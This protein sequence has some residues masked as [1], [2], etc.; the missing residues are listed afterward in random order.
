MRTP[1]PQASAPGDIAALCAG[2]ASRA[3]ISWNAQRPPAGRQSLE[4]PSRSPPDTT[5][6]WVAAQRGVESA[7]LTAIFHSGAR[8]GQDRVKTKTA[9]RHTG[10]ERSARPEYLVARLAL[11]EAWTVEDLTDALGRE[12]GTTI[13]WVPVPPGFPHELCG[14]HLSGRDVTVLCY[15]ES[16]EP[17]ASRQAH[18][19][20][21][22]HHLLDNGLEVHGVPQVLDAL[23][24][25]SSADEAK[26]D[27]ARAE[28]EADHLAAMILLSP[29]RRS[30]RRVSPCSARS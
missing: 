30:R 5:S 7:R 10:R 8:G 2:P 24:S 4:S 1:P 13:V 3:H 29:S 12:C 21:A 28:C 25:G 18:A 15:R 23:V 11:P 22:A 20:A 6:A 26:V 9:A 14:V 19:H 17:S 16:D 27:A